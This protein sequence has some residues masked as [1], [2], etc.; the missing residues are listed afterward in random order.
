MKFIYI[1]LILILLGCS[2]KQQTK[3]FEL[4]SYSVFESYVSTTKIY[5]KQLCNGN[6][7][8]S[9]DIK[10]SRAQIE[11]IVNEAQTINFFELPSTITHPLAP[12][13]FI[14]EDIERIDIC[15]PCST[16]ALYLKIGNKSHK[17]SWPCNCSNFNEPTPK[18]LRKLV[19]TVND[20][21][22]SSAAYIQA[23]ESFCRLR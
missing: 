1:L 11:R 3:S 13:P 20:S 9:G 19:N 22:K 6:L 21:I 16:T 15:A 2:S 4:G 18:I 7:D 5:N 23:P 8:Y 12:M 10:F 14:Q 17:V